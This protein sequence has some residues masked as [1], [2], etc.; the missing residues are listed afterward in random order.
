MKLQ[1]QIY[2][3]DGVYAS[4]D[5]YQIRLAANSPTEPTDVVFLD[6]STY[7]AL[8]RYVASL[9]AADVLTPEG[10]A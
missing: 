10:D 3:G 4:Y 5:G 1:H 9:Y 6:A 7:N 2:L 8:L